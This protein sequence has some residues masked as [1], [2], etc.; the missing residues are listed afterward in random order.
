MNIVI[1]E[2]QFSQNLSPLSLLKPVYDIRTGVFTN[3]ERIEFLFGKDYKIQYH[4]REILSEYVS[5]IKKQKVNIFE[6][7]NTVF[8]N[9][10]IIFKKSLIDKLIKSE[11]EFIWTNG[12]IIIAAFLNSNSVSKFNLLFNNNQIKDTLPFL[13]FANEY[14]IDI[15][16][17][18]S[19]NVIPDKD[20]FIINYPWD[21]V[22][23]FNG[24]LNDDLEF[25]DYYSAI[26]ESSDFRLI[27]PKDIFISE[28]ARILPYTVLDATSGK[29]F[30][31]NDVQI[32]PFTYI[33]G[34]VYIAS[35]SIV[36]SGTKI[37][38]PASIGFNSRVAGEISG[39]IFHSFVNKQ[40][41]GFIGNSYVAEFVN[42]GADTVTSNLK[43]N[44][45]PIKA[46][47]KKDSIQYQTGL[48][49]F[50]SIIGD[51]TKTG[52]NTMLNTGSIIGIFALIAGGGFPDKFID[53]FSWYITGKPITKY[54]I[55]EALHTAKIVMGRRE[56]EL[57]P[58]YEKLIKNVYNSFL[59][60]H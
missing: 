34:P 2:D 55:E 41:D 7:K 6:E 1:F 16:N 33:K 52:I 23:Y 22:K 21:I 29:I 11:K 51:H 49:F 17:N 3:S 8:I 35:K 27:N 38:G 15:L 54:K 59:D 46:R 47:F 36:K 53:S 44:Y 60:S 28:S 30:I 39:T 57:T 37:Y 25:F 42:L 10:R 13:N 9:G 58:A 32:E 48:T 50:G 40:H 19:F 45:S 56:Q 4:C 43:N 31:E 18:E 12:D 24:V 26:N 14:K 5:E 20:F